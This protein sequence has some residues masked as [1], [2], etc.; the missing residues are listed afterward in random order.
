MALNFPSRQ[1]NGALQIGSR[2]MRRQC[3][4]SEPTPPQ[5]AGI[6]ICTAG[7]EG[8]GRGLTA[9][10]GYDQVFAYLPEPRRCRGVVGGAAGLPLFA[11]REVRTAHT[12]DLW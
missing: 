7:K 1:R 12:L 3:G 5:A 9:G 8:P 11:V 4:S 6:R 10:R 2:G